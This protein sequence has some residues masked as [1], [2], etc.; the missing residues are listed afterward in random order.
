MHVAAAEQATGTLLFTLQ[1]LQLLAR[2]AIAHPPRGARNGGT[3]YLASLLAVY[4]YTHFTHKRALLTA[5]YPLPRP[6]PAHCLSLS[7]EQQQWP[8]RAV[9]IFSSLLA[10]VL[11]PPSSFCTLQ[12]RLQATQRP[13]CSLPIVAPS[14][15]GE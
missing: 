3:L 5:R 6:P 15:K 4:V 7:L 9:T 14:R 12:A 11:F 1:F 10:L 8:C 13:P 2:M